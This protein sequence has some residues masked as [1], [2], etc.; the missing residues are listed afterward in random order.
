M[1]VNEP[2]VDKVDSDR[3]TLSIYSRSTFTF[4]FTSTF[5][6]LLL[7]PCVLHVIISEKNTLSSSSSSS[8]SHSTNSPVIGRPQVLCII[9]AKSKTTETYQP[10]NNKQKHIN[11]LLRGIRCGKPYQFAC[12]SC[13]IMPL[14]TMTGGDLPFDFCRHQV[15][16]VK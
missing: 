5:A 7:V 13:S 6:I 4:T 11:L 16:I 3:P 14:V 10:M 1:N 15:N 12:F 9:A 8:S 2:R